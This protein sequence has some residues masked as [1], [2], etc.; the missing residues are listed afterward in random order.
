MVFIDSLTEPKIIIR[1]SGDPLLTTNDLDSMA[2]FLAQHLPSKTSWNLIGDATL[3]DDVP[4][5][6]GWMWDD[7]PDP[8]AV[9]I[10]ALS[11]N[12]NCIGIRVEP[13]L[14]TNQPVSVAT[15]PRTS[16]VT[17]HNEGVTTEARSDSLFIS[18]TSRDGEN[19][20]SVGGTISILDSVHIEELS[21]RNPEEFFL[22][23]LAERLTNQGMVV[24]TKGLAKVGE[25]GQP[26]MVL[27]RPL[28]DVIISLNKES[29]NLC[30]EV[31]LKT[32]G[33]EMMGTPGTSENG[34]L[35]LSRFLAQIGIDTSD[36]V[37]ADGSGVSRYNLTTSSAIV[38]VLKAMYAEP[39]HFDLFYDSLPI[40]GVDGTL[41][42]RM[43]G[44]T[45]EGN[46]RA[47]TGTLSGVSS[48]SG[49]VRTADNEL[50]AFSIVM[51]NFPSGAKDYREVQDKIGVLLSNLRRGSVPDRDKVFSG[52]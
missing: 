39:W 17:I 20:I 21:I 25:L 52:E 29:D 15:V 23:L 8:D 37:I 44:T 35:A 40:A 16:F 3:F 50:L 32:L 36:V 6:K 7:E 47:K 41:L 33:G 10:S 1:G 38:E 24:V 28:R 46:L 26:S 19:L 31:L 4:W 12:K 30:A 49:Y 14:S 43:K 34:A 51:E 13:G 11:V 5:G 45:A 27:S 2:S 22:N 18:R 48:L 42:E 9:F